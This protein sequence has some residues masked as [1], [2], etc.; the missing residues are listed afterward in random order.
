MLAAAL[1]IDAFAAAFAYG[2]SR[3]RVKLS[4]ALIISAICSIFLAISL[5]IGRILLPAIP[6]HAAK[7]ICFLILFCLGIEKL[8]ECFIKALIIRKKVVHSSIGF[9]FA[10]LHFILNIY[11]DPIEAD[12]D[13][14]K[15]LS[16][17]ESV[18]L[19][20]AMSLDGIAAGFGVSLTGGSIGW[21]I[22]LSF[23][24]GFAMIRTG[25]VLGR[26]IAGK[27]KMDLSWF[28]GCLLILLAFL[29]L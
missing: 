1:S 17:K 18:A 21:I 9:H 13:S 6:Q 29:K 2:N 20:I 4:S 26:L 24:F 11:A 7:V 12:V 15:V 8:F 19:A 25:E 14:S 27:G 28:G 3:I 10:S 23:V 16:P 5:G 22:V